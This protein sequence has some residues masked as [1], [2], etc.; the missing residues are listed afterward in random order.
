MIHAKSTDKRVHYLCKNT[1]NKIISLLGQDRKCCLTSS[2]VFVIYSKTIIGDKVGMQSGKNKSEINSIID[3]GL[4]ID[5]KLQFKEQVF[6]R[7]AKLI[8]I[9]GKTGEEFWV[10]PALF[11]FS[12]M[13]KKTSSSHRY[14]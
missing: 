13:L 9:R 10:I 8:L 2:A 5:S 11:I 6:C 1:Q 4:I 3:L 7:I 12:S 14:N